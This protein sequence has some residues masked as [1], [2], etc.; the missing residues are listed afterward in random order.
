MDLLVVTPSVVAS[1]AVPIPRGSRVALRPWASLDEQ[2]Y[3]VDFRTR[4]AYR[5]LTI[6]DKQLR[7]GGFL[8]STCMDFHHS[9]SRH[10]TSFYLSVD[11][12]H[13]EIRFLEAD[14]LTRVR[15]YGVQSQSLPNDKALLSV[16][17]FEHSLRA[18][19]FDFSGA[20]VLVSGCGL[21]G[22]LIATLN[23]GAAQVVGVEPQGEALMI[24]QCLTK[25]FEGIR[26]VSDLTGDLSHRFDFALSRHVLEHIEQLVRRSYLDSLIGCLRPGGVLFIEVPNQDCPIEPHTDIEFFHWLDSDDRERAIAY[27]R[28]REQAGTYPSERLRRLRSLARHSNISLAELRELCGDLG[29]FAWE[30]SDSSMIGTDACG[31]TI[32][33][34]ISTKI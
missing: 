15:Q 31:D 16:A 19:G 5:N 3:L 14:N 21:G 23:L 18:T 34:W 29:S 25:S 10:H 7:L 12:R 24:A 1:V 2:C 20:S 4:R 32:R 22:E 30:Y 17:R 6:S 8:R 13:W 27:L 28:R 26:V 9:D 11:D 33:A